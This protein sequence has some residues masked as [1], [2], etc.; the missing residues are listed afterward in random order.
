MMNFPEG[1]WC[2]LL[3]LRPTENCDRLFFRVY[4]AM[5]ELGEGGGGDF[6]GQPRFRLPC[7][8]VKWERGYYYFRWNRML[9]YQHDAKQESGAHTIMTDAVATLQ[10]NMR[11]VYAKQSDTILSGFVCDPL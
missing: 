11:T 9:K 5:A 4:H 1:D 6:S 8:M 3:L 2:L 7:V 10:L